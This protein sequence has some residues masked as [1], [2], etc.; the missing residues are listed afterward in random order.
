MQDRRVSGARTAQR[1][2]VNA[3]MSSDFSVQAVTV[4]RTGNDGTTEQKSAAMVTAPPPAET[5]T[6]PS[7][8][9]NPT[10]RLEPSL[11]LVVIEFRNDTGA[12]TT[13]IPSQRQ[14]EA[15]QRWAQ[16]HS[17]PSSSQSVP[18]AMINGS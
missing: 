5:A 17:G 14:I 11:G 10:L 15:Y 13:S 3:A 1:S 18:T 2:A 9:I 4:A 12:I 7:P 16:T 8:I 6:P